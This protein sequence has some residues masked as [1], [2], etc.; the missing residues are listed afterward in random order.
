MQFAVFVVVGWKKIESI[1]FNIEVLRE[2]ERAGP[3]KM[4]GCF[5]RRASQNACVVS[6]VLCDL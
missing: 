5:A 6:F 2:R 1:F 3:L 4:I